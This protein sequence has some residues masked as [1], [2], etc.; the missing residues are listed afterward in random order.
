MKNRPRF[1]SFLIFV[2]IA[3]ASFESIAQTTAPRA[4]Q[5][6]NAADAHGSEPSLRPSPRRIT[7]L[8]LTEMPGG[9]R[10]IIAS[11]T[12][13]D[14]YTA[15]R[16]GDRFNIRIP[17]A[18]A[19]FPSAKI[20]GRGLSS[21][22]VEQQGD[23]VRL[24]FQLQE[25]A[26]VHLSKG[27]NRL[28]LVFTVPE[29]ASATETSTPVATRSNVSAPTSNGNDDR[30]ALRQMRAQMEQLEAR[31]KELEG[32]QSKTDT[33][34]TAPNAPQVASVAQ[35][36]V[37]AATKPASKAT[38]A[39]AND[40]QHDEMPM[41]TPH[42]QI[43]GFADVDYRASTQKGTT[44]S[45]ALGQLDLFITSKLSEKFSVLSELILEANQQNE[46]SIEVHR[47]LLKYQPNDYFSLSA[48]RYHTAIGYYNTAYHHG[49]WFQTAA[50]RPF[51]FAFESRGGILPLHNVGFSITGR[52]PN[53][54]FGL[55]YI[56]EVGNG[57]ASRS[58]LDHPVQSVVDENNGKAYNLGMFAR[59]SKIPGF[60]TG[61]SVYHD[62]LT[63]GGLPK[64]RQTI[65]AGYVVYQNP[66]Y[67]FLNELVVLRHDLNGRVFQTPGFYSQV[68]RRFGNAKP[69]FR[70]QYVNVPSD[71]PIFPEVGRRNGPSLGLRYDLTDFAAFKAQF[72]RTQRRGFDTFNDF[73]LQLAFTF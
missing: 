66:R 60:Q 35:P 61:V 20:E 23:E 68:A 43:Q 42:L 48:G 45:F 33:T 71:D 29:Q 1:I 7:P 64:I 69:Y 30:E 13:F 47:L 67:E 21:A 49:S 56:A 32:K 40:E 17:N 5:T 27:F 73:I 14:D 15:S 16:D 53:A 24:S 6:R 26:T 22:Q 62:Q 25:G 18:V 65:M 72:D 19:S 28:E 41:G 46:F 37:S 34:Q 59:P 39:S 36:V 12:A 9:S 63:P 8:R 38:Q 55:H 57:R 50:D 58:R 51:I 70:Y 52:I 3:L 44:N 11:D 10:V 31:I 54:P 4:A 2:L